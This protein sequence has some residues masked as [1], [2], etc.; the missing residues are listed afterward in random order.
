[1]LEIKGLGAEAQELA[2]GLGADK[3][4]GCLRAFF[5]TC[6]PLMIF[7]VFVIFRYT[8][9]LFCTPLVKPLPLV[10]WGIRL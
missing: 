3:N 2:G 8:Y 9:L 4:H 1:V 10:E 7:T 5:C 6:C